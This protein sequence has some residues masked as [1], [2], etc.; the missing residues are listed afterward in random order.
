MNM[1]KLNDVLLT[2]L[3]KNMEAN[4]SNT[5]MKMAYV[6]VLVLLTATTD[7]K[8]HGSIQKYSDRRFNDL[9]RYNSTKKITR[10]QP[11]TSEDP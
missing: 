8:T 7:Q 10:T 5:T 9:S 11:A 4:F 1:Q 3:Y 6:E 2:T